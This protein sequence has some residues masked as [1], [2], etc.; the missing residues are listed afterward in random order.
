MLQT[1]TA[2]SPLP[3]SY[4]DF[5]RNSGANSANNEQRRWI[6]AAGERFVL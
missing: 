6:R 2:Y 4:L 3:V 5:W 1:V